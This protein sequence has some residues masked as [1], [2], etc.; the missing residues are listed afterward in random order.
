MREFEL[1]VDLP[2]LEKGTHFI[3]D[4]DTSHV[5]WITDNGD[6]SEYPLRPGLAGYLWLLATEIKCMRCIGVR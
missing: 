1:M 2:F 3:M 4:D 5:F 6:V